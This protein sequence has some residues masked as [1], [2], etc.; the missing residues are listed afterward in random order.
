MAKKALELAE[1]NPDF[2]YEAPDGR[3]C[4]YMDGEGQPSCLFG[5]ALVGLGVDIPE[6]W[7]DK[8]ISEVLRYIFVPDE[9]VRVDALLARWGGLDTAQS[10]QDEGSPWSEVA[11]P[12]RSWIKANS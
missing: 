5:Q 7:E 8:A 3:G 4:V 12:L 9:D 11:Q 10:C 1:A 6:A 2:V